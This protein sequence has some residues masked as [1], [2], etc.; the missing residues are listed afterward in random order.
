MKM[1]MCL[2]VLLLCGGLARAEFANPHG[3][4]VI[5][6]NKDYENTENVDFAHN[7][8]D[9]FRRY[10]VEVLGFNPDR[11]KVLKDAEKSDFDLMFG[12]RDSHQETTLWDLLDTEH[13]SDVVVFYSGHGA[14]SMGDGRGYLLPVDALPHKARLTGYPLDVLWGEPGEAGR[15]RIGGGVRGRV[16][17]G[18]Q[19]YGDTVQG[20]FFGSRRCAVA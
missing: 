1:V 6:G 16:F 10:V 2:A 14:P 13:R 8:A 18:R 19:R 15:N 17:F 11:V 7:D 9:E 3:I 4:A 12:V 20:D 5:I